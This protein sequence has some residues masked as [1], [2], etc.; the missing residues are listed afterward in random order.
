MIMM[1][2]FISG[3]FFENVVGVDTSKK[4]QNKRTEYEYVRNSCVNILGYGKSQ[5]V[6]WSYPRYTI[7]DG[8]SFACAN[9]TK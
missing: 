4:K 9:V 8:N 5:K 2:Q 7:M 6:A 1:E 3:F